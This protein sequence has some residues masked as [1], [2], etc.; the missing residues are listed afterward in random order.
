MTSIARLA[1]LTVLALTAPGAWGVA[2]GELYAHAA[3]SL[4]KGPGARFGV[5]S[6]V[7]AGTAITVL[8]CNASADWCLLDSGAAQ[9]WAPIADITAKGDKADESNPAVAGTQS[10][11]PG[12]TAS[13]GDT[14]SAGGGAATVAV[15]VGGSNGISVGVASP[16]G[17]VNAK[18]P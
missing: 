4:H 6:T 11:S 5:A 10:V 13:A 12:T 9:G 15:S 7:P 8:W 18:L 17:S 14:A 2:S 3:L 1:A 16:A